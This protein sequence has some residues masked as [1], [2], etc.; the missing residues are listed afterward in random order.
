MTDITYM[1]GYDEPGD[2]RKSETP[3]FG[4][5]ELRDAVPFHINRIVVHNDEALRDHIIELL[6]SGLKGY[7]VVSPADSAGGLH[8]VLKK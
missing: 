1:K 8:G 5:S 3:S 6:N 2:P 7:R 4:I